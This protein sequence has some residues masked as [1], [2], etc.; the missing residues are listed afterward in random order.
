[1]VTFFSINI[2]LLIARLTIKFKISTTKQK[3]KQL[4]KITNAN[5][6]IEKSLDCNFNF[7]FDHVFFK[8]KDFFSVIYCQKFSKILIKFL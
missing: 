5:K 6:Y 7:F 1:M 4:I 3:C 8:V 2:I